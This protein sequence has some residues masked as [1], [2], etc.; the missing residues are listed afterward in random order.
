MYEQNRSVLPV[1]RKEGWQLWRR[2]VLANL[3]AEL[4]GLGLAAL[5]SSGINWFS[6]GVSGPALVLSGMLSSVLNG[7]A[8]G[9]A[10]GLAQW[11]ILRRYLPWIA[12][13]SWLAVT[14]SG[15]VVGSFVGMIV[16]GN[17]D[18]N[19]LNIAMGMIALGI[20]LLTAL[21][22]ALLGFFQWLILH[23]DLSQS[24]LWIVANALAW[25]LGLA[26]AFTGAG[27]LPGNLT[28]LLL[29][30]LGSGIT[31][32]ACVT[33]GVVHGLILLYLFRQSSPQ[34]GTAILHE[35]V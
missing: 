15:L 14:S 17:L 7:L 10:I 26:I 20:L 6:S 18:L 9:L 29:L 1:G 31:L 27:L 16:G 12:A 23:Q 28:F 24:G 35:R 2:W 21:L 33:I 19:A 3:C 13:R 34:S 30:L 32:A 5:V 11:W 22:G 25:M 4:V 8:M